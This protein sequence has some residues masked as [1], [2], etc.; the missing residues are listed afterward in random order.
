MAHCMPSSVTTMLLD[1]PLLID[2]FEFVQRDGDFAAG[3]PNAE[4]PVSHFKTRG[5]RF[6]IT[7]QR[8][9]INHP[10]IGGAEFKRL[11]HL[12]AYADRPIF[13]RK[14]FDPKQGR[15][16]DDFRPGTSTD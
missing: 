7:L 6:H 11:A 5:P 4:N 9:G 14:N 10:N 16:G 12:A 8:L 2:L 3:A 13:A 15:S 1:N